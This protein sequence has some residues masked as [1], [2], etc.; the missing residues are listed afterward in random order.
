MG[1]VRMQLSL[2]AM[3]SWVGLTAV[4]VA[5][6]GAW[7]TWH[8]AGREGLIG[9][10]V[11][12]AIVLPVMFASASI[13]LRVARRGPGRTTLAFIVAGMGRLMVVLSVTVPV[14]LV[15]GVHTAAVL[16]WVSVF[17]LT[18]LA[19]EVVWLARALKRDAFWV[20]LGR[21]DRPSPW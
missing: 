11:A 9:M 7:P 10:L 1:T 19:G 13:V 5:A 4:L 12:G 8:L 21:I 14:C 16:A 6:A 2:W 20:A 3:L 15:S 18:T 17:Y